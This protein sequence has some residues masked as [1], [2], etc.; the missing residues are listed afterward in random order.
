MCYKEITQKCLKEQEK[1]GVE[2]PLVKFVEWQLLIDYAGLP[3]SHTVHE[4]KKMVAY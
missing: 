4:A 2:E 1:V 3:I